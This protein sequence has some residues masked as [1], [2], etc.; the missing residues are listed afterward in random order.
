MPWAPCCSFPAIL[1]IAAGVTYG[2]LGFPVMVV[3]ATTGAGLAF[4]IARYF[5]RARVERTIEG[6]T[7]LKAIDDAVDDEGWRIVALLRLSPLV[8]F[9]LQNYVFGATSVGF[10]PYL[11]ATL[12]G[13]MPGVLLYVWIGS[14][15]GM[16]GGGGTSTLKWTFFAVGIVATGIVTWLIGRKAREKLNRTG[17]PED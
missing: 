1:T 9:N 7:K 13:I 2:F 15:G 17:L 5:A 3:G 11:L 12:F 16:A 6:N 14:L 8:P 10:W 4:L